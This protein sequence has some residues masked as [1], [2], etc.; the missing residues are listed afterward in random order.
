MKNELED[1]ENT[2]LGKSI[3][4][5]PTETYYKEGIITGVNNIG[6]LVKITK[7]ERVLRGYLFSRFNTFYQFR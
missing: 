6:I 1:F 4:L 2:F 5:Y 3:R 7:T